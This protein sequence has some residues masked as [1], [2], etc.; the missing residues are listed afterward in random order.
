MT[1]QEFYGV[2]MPVVEY[3]KADLS[4]AVIALYF[5]DLGHLEASELKRGLR[6]LRQSR[7]YSNMPTIAEI[8]EAVEGDF[9]SK[10]QL[11]LDDLI[12]AINKYGPDRSVCFSDNAIMSVVKAAGGWEAVGNLKGKEW[13]DF[14]KWEFKKLYKTYSKPNQTAPA[15]LI[16]KHERENSFSNQSGKFDKV[17]F[18]GMDKEPIPALEFKE[19]LA[20]ISPTNKLLAGI[21]KAA[22]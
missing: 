20:K 10:A 19:G 12:Y 5:E 14:K 17:Y 6:E 18:I 21:N 3:Y 16:G 8:I 7:K 9:E 4:K 13:E 22:V 15:Y 11:A 2:F 1:I